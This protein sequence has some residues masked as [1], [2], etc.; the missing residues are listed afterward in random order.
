[1]KEEGAIGF[2]TDEIAMPV[3]P[4]F[5]FERIQWS[6]NDIVACSGIILICSLNTCK[7]MALFPVDGIKGGNRNRNIISS[8]EAYHRTWSWLQRYCNLKENELIK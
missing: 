3:I 5:V 1:V 2:M 8:E 6:V 4:L 7:R